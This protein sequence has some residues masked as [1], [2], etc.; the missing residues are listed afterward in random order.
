MLGVDIVNLERIKDNYDDLARRLL[1]DKERAQLLTYKAK[2]SKISYIGG[3]F[4]AKEAYVKASG[5]K[6]VNYKE[7]EIIDDMNGRPHIYINDCEI[8]EVSIAHD[9]YAIAVV[10]LFKEKK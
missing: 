10:S 2:T 1:S 9:G 3:R 4:A 6:L 5:N 7:V 8:G